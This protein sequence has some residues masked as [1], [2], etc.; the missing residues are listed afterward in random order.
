M[1][2]LVL[3]PQNTQHLFTK[4]QLDLTK[5]LLGECERIF[6]MLIKINPELPRLI[7]ILKAFD[8]SLQTEG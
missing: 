1:N 5:Y 8:N 2:S 4:V 3:F 6:S 7:V